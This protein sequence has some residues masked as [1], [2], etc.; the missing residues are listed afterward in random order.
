MKKYVLLILIGLLTL[1][2][3]KRAD[4][5]LIM[6]TEA[7]F[8]PYEFYQDGQIVG[9]DIEIAKEIAKELDKKLVVKD[10]S[11]DSIVNELKS[12][13]ADFAAA[14]MSITEDRKKQVDFTIEYT[15]S[16][17][18]VIVR[19]DSPITDISDIKDK[20]ISVQ[21]GTVADSYVTENYKNA[22][23]NRL[24][25]FL[26][27]AE[28]VKNNKSDCIVMDLLPALELV[29][30]NDE[31]KILD[32][33]LFQDKYGMALKKGNKELLDDINKVLKRLMDEGKIEEYIVT[34]SK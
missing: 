7:G 31:L 22:K 8:A 3:C 14:G 34:F 16:N 25:K 10:V 12:G 27:A 17:Q 9:V 30:K 11:F 20:R 29:K 18:V 33:I 19:K 4:N 28:D 2:G 32:G 23:I 21:L 5:E 24:K 15:V 1:T 13:K 26:V 6:V